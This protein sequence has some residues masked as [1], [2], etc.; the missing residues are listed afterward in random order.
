MSHV[1]K[2]LLCHAKHAQESA[3][4]QCRNRTEPITLKIKLHG[5]IET[6]KILCKSH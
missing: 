4:V 5:N 6:L 3:Q 1:N 2:I